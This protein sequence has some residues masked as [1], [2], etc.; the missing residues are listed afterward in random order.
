MEKILV[1]SGNIGNYVA[2]SLAQKNVSVRVLVRTIK[3]NRK[4]DAL[5]IEQ[6]AGDLGNVRSLAPAFDGVDRFFSVTP[7]LE[8]LVELGTNA[9]EAAKKAGVAHIVRSSAMGASENAITIGRWHYAVERAIEASGIPYT[10][11]QPNTFMQSYFMNAETIK[12]ANA[13]YMPQG[14]GKVSLVD[15]RDIA[16]VAVACLTDGGHR[17]KNMCSP[18]TKRCPTR[19]SRRN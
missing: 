9:V 2:E 18:G 12:T 3:P 11:L 8:N 10:I 17:G 6:V 1:T 5:G 19:R 13:F 4:W 16:A 7:M 14:D 15:V